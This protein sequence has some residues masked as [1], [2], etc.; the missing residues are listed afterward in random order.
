[1][2]EHSAFRLLHLYY[3]GAYTSHYCFLP[4]DHA[5]NKESLKRS[6][7]CPDCLGMFSEEQTDNACTASVLQ[8]AGERE[9]R[10]R[11]ARENGLPSERNQWGMGM[12]MSGSLT[13]LGGCP[14]PRGASRGAGLPSA[15]KLGR[16]RLWPHSPHLPPH[17][18]PVIFAQTQGFNYQA[19]RPEQPGASWQQN[20]GGPLG[21]ASQAGGCYY[22][23]SQRL[24]SPATAADRTGFTTG[25]H[26][27]LLGKHHLFEYL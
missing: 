2:T 17:Q 10:P 3:L 7:S 26:T 12:V 13:G 21:S 6:P 5:S 27:V 23:Q 19:G 24:R 8:G 1:M 22:P 25:F 15:P 20:T 4:Q 18:A 9:V 11:R 16:V 14:A